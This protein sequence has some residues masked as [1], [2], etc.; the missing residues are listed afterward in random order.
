MVRRAVVRFEAVDAAF[1]TRCVFVSI[2][3]KICG[4]IFSGAIAVDGEP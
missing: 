1:V 2:A 3:E 4:R